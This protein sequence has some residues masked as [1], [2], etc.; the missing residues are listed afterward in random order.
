MKTLGKKKSLW[1]RGLLKGI[2]TWL[3]SCRPTIEAH[4]RSARLFD[5]NQ[6]VIVALWHSTLIY[7]LFHFKTFPAAIMVSASKDGEWV[8]RALR[9][10]G[11]YP[12]RGSR[13]KGG[14]MAIRE[15]TRLIDRQAVSAGIVADGSKGP[16][17]VAQKG[18]V[19]LARNTGLPIVPV[20]MAARPAY[21]F[22]TWDRL[23]LP[24]PFSKVAVVYG[25]PLYVD[26]NDRGIQLEHARIHL[27]QRLISASK[28]AKKLVKA[29]SKENIK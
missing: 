23:L 26:E 15:M 17:Y 18:A 10:W 20:G 12:V 29:D 25:P 16:P 22:K 3:S 5:L 1:L 2:E 7:C 6:Q 4:P 24:L 28:R 11:Q 14:I 27:E 8:A 13:L 9:I 21:H 19:V